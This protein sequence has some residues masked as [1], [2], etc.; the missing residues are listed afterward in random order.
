MLFLR[1][2]FAP[3]D[4]SV[5]YKSSLFSSSYGKGKRFKYLEYSNSSI[6]YGFWRYFSHFE[7]LID[8][9]RFVNVKL[10]ARS[11]VV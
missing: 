5:I 9:I 6:I 10:N 8:K 11:M 4:L 1:T 7:W 2:L 3:L